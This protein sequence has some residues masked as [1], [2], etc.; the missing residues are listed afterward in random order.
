MSGQACSGNPLSI[1]G[2]F[3]ILSIQLKQVKSREPTRGLEPLYCSSYE[4]A[5][6]GC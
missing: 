1:S 4:C 3:V 6:R 5:V 2:D